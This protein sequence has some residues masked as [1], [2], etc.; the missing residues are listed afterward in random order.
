MRRQDMQWLVLF[1]VGATA[2]GPPVTTPISVEGTM[3]EPRS[4]AYAS[5]RG[6]RELYIGTEEYT[7]AVFLVS[8]LEDVCAE[9]PTIDPCAFGCTNET[10]TAETIETPLLQV[11]AN[12]PDTIPLLE[13]YRT[14]LAH[15]DAFSWRFSHG[16]AADRADPITMADEGTLHDLQL[17]A[18]RGQGRYEVTVEGVRLEGSLAGVRCGALEAVLSCE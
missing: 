16:L 10:G 8:A 7:L 4:V 15:G 3:L 6:E 13:S 9:V 14:R 5:C 11:V 2:C 18:E 1:G 12:L 17:S